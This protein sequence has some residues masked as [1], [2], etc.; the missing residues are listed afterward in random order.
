VKRHE[1]ETRPQPVVVARRDLDTSASRDDPDDLALPDAEESQLTL[2]WLAR[3][4]GAQVATWTLIED[5][6]EQRAALG[7]EI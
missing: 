5:T 6:P 1:A 2:I 4:E 7:L 3:I